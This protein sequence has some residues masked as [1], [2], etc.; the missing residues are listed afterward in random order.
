MDKARG[1]K[2]MCGSERRDELSEYTLVDGRRCRLVVP[3]FAVGGSE[4]WR[5]RRAREEQS[6]AGEAAS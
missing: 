1:L 5:L 2:A 4:P 6:P 3:S